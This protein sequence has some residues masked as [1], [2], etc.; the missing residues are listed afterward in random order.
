MKPFKARLSF[1]VVL[2]LDALAASGSDMHQLAQEYEAFLQSKQ[3]HSDTAPMQIE[4]VRETL[5]M[6]KVEIAEIKGMTKLG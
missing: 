5:Y 1:T 2:E 4:A 6:S 3:W